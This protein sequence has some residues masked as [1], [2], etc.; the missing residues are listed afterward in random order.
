[1]SSNSTSKG[2]A[3]NPKKQKYGLKNNNLKYEKRKRELKQKQEQ[4]KAIKATE[5]AKAKA[6]HQIFITMLCENNPKA[7]LIRALVP[8]DNVPRDGGPSDRAFFLGRAKNPP[9]RKG[10]TPARY[11]KAPWDTQYPNEG[12]P[13]S[14]QSPSGDELV[15]FFMDPTDQGAEAKYFLSDCENY[16]LFRNV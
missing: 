9:T 7:A 16:V 14:V 3:I 6:T 13:L 10:A 15:T 2:A 8:E 4:K 1:M 11:Q 12:L 5:T